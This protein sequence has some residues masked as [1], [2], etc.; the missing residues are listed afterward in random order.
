MK[1]CTKFER[2]RAIRGRVIGLSIFDLMTLNTKLGENIGRSWLH[3]EF[4]SEIG[5]LAAFS[6]AGGSVLTDV[7]NDAKIH[8]F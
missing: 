8:T 2:N 3:K 1:L 7:E 5:Y 4:V 6:N